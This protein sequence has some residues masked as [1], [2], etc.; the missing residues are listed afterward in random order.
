M[1][2][3]NEVEP[4][5][6]FAL[7]ALGKEDVQLSACQFLLQSQAVS[8]ICRHLLRCWHN[9]RGFSARAGSLEGFAPE[10]ACQNSQK[11]RVSA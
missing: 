4:S 10:E 11:T 1:S 7:I 9:I 5:S 3:D 2:T 8:A 6:Y